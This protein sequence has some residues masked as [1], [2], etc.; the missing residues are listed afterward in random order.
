MNISRGIGLVFVL[1]AIACSSD[2]G[3]RMAEAWMGRRAT[4]KRGSMPASTGQTVETGETPPTCRRWRRGTGDADSSSDAAD[5]S[6]DAADAR[7]STAD[8]S[9]ARDGADTGADVRPTFCPTSARRCAAPRR[10]ARRSIVA[11]AHVAFA[12]PWEPPAA[13]VTEGVPSNDCH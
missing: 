1:A 13:P 7:D 12:P 6:R 10:A 11:T 4:P 5:G 3:P 8:G 2:E 9:D